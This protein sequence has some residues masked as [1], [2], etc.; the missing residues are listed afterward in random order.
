MHT[1]KPE[2]LTGFGY[3]FGFSYPS[4]NSNPKTRKNRVPKPEPEPEKPEKTGFSYPKKSGTSHFFKLD[5]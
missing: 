1:L 4:P 3:M 2:N 5:A